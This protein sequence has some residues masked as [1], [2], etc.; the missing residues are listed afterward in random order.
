MKYLVIA[1]RMIFGGWMV[2][3]GLNHWFHFTPQPFGQNPVSI[4]F[5]TVLIESG[6][7]D[8][9]KAMET[10]TGALVLMGVFV[11]LAL[12]AALPI[13]V[14]VAYFNLVL[15]HNGVVNYVAGT[16]V[17]GI[18][19]LLMLAYV[20]SYRPLLRWKQPVAAGY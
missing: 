10:I 16:L 7:F 4:E 17:L 15:E 9:V 20:D 3:A 19:L 14:V 12:V 5:T 18:N 2:Y 13:S 8:L 1:G 11:P 6:L